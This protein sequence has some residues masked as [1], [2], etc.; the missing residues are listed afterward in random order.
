MNGNR[1]NGMPLPKQAT[2][3][4]NNSGRQQRNGSGGN[5]H[6]SYERY[7]ALGREASLNGDAVEAENYYQ[8]AEHYFRIMR[9]RPA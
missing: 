6:R 1:R 2:R 3:R 8:H 9:E 7:M 5:A 4:M